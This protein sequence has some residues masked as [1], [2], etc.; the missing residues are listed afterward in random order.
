MKHATKLLQGK[1]KRSSGQ[2]I[3]VA[4][5]DQVAISEIIENPELFEQYKDHL[6]VRRDNLPTQEEFVDYLRTVTSAKAII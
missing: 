2:R 5:A 6:M 1:D 3:Q 4:L